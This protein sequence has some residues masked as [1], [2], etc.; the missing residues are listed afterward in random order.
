[1]ISTSC[2]ACDS[3]VLLPLVAHSLRRRY[4][5][6]LRSW[7]AL[8]VHRW[9][10]CPVDF[11][12]LHGLPWQVGV[13][14]LCSFESN[15]NCTCNYGSFTLLFFTILIGLLRHSL[16][17]QCCLHR[18]FLS[19]TGIPLAGLPICL[20]P[21]RGSCR[22]TRHA[23]LH[24]VWKL[25]S[26]THPWKPNKLAYCTP[27]ILVATASP[28]QRR[29]GGIRRFEFRTGEEKAIFSAPLF[30]STRV[31]GAD[32]PS[33]WVVREDEDTMDHG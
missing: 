20:G 24:L 13:G 19:Q 10:V 30:V 28:V 9:A 26:F 1:M 29:K 32:T 11:S 12:A 14:C 15:G 5:I 4:V 25:L 3:V 33:G 18:C 8:V 16:R 31:V 2:C 17:L 6:I 27:G 21:P 22:S 23:L 7:L